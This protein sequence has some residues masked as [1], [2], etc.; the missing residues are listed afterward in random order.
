MMKS[1]LSY[2]SK[3]QSIEP[4]KSDVVSILKDYLKCTNYSLKQVFEEIDITK[5]GRVTN[6]EF[7]EAIRKLMTG[8]TSKEIDDLINVTP[9]GKDGKIDYNLFINSMTETYAKY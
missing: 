1:G 2:T 3:L 5:C 8:M 7:K 9:M 4:N 6:L